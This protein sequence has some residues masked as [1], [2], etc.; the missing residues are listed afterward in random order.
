RKELTEKEHALLLAGL[1]DK[2]PFVQRCAADAIGK[3]A[4]P[5]NLT[6]LLELRHKVP[7]ADTHLLHTVRMAIRDTM[8]IPESWT[9]FA[10]LHERDKKAIAD[11]AVGVPTKESAKSLMDGL[12]EYAKDRNQLLTL[13]HHIARHGDADVTRRLISFARSHDAANK[14][15]QAALFQTIEQ[16]TQER[17]AALSDDALAW[18]KTIAT[19]LLESRDGN[20]LLLGIRLAG[21]LR[22]KE[23]QNKL[24][25]VAANTDAS[26]NLRVEAIKSLVLLDDHKYT[27]LLG[28]I[29][30]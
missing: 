25:S 20:E 7:A 4:T 18:G 3:H 26:E 19:E 6:A 29:L 21:S 12:N 1:K 14:G 9:Q 16:G 17:G 27:G 30:A 5:D 15:L 10:S 13:C 23:T 22:L 24:A 8:R 11:V 2:D 28:R